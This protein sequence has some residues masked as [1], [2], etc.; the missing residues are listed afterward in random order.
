M[1]LTQIVVENDCIWGQSDCSRS[2]MKDSFLV[3]K[4]LYFPGQNKEMTP[5]QG[6]K[7]LYSRVRI[8]KWPQNVSQGGFISKVVKTYFER[9]AVKTRFKPVKTGLNR[10]KRGQ[11]LKLR[12]KRTDLN[13]WIADSHGFATGNTWTSAAHRRSTRE[14]GLRPLASSVDLDICWHDLN[15]RAVYS[16]I[17][18][19][20]LDRRNT[21]EDTIV[22]TTANECRGPYIPIGLCFWE[23]AFIGRK[24]L[25]S[26]DV[27]NF[28]KSHLTS[29]DLCDFWGLKVR[30]NQSMQCGF[31]LSK[32]WSR[33]VYKKNPK[34]FELKLTPSANELSKSSNVEK[35]Q[36]GHHEL[37]NAWHLISTVIYCLK[38][39][40]SK[41]DTTPTW[42]T[43]PVLV[44]FKNRYHRTG[45]LRSSPL[46]VLYLILKLRHIHLQKVSFVSSLMQSM[47][48]TLIL[49]AGSEGNSRACTA[50]A[51][52]A[53]TCWTRTL[54]HWHSRSCTLGMA[55]LASTM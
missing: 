34:Y 17:Y 26:Y 29:A 28:W 40:F 38:H 2:H 19:G 25:S 41:M 49:S 36:I 39:V 3:K 14:L 35:F 7:W 4:W 27:V 11:N 48:F 12:N 32:L 10:S 33:R 6:W 22:H 16:V 24:F 21:C 15:Q 54:C 45:L 55:M 50:N 9:K 18:T 13:T 1:N 20:G 43:N 37:L 52:G 44:I 23:R 47:L 30:E 5:T 51:M 8:R 31:A 46:Q 53:E 42:P